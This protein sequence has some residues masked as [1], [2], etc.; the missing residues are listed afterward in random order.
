VQTSR[1]ISGTNPARRAASGVGVGR[2]FGCCAGGWRRP[3]S[4]ERRA[5]HLGEFLA[6]L[7]EPAP[8]VRGLLQPRARR[9]L[10]PAGLLADRYGRKRL[11][12]V[13]LA[14]FAASSAG[15]AYAG[16][17]VA[18]IAIRAVLGGGAAIIVTVSLSILAVLFLPMR[19]DRRRQ[20]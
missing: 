14:V 1:Q 17:P 12:L 4:P 7:H 10:R 2:A 5:A 13:S 6:C 16:S 11:L 19:N 18:L 15:C 9:L 3:D 8:V 20:Q